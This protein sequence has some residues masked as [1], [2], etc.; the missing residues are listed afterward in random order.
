MIFHPVDNSG[1]T[2]TFLCFLS[3]SPSL[4]L[5]FG[6]SAPRRSYKLISFDKILKKLVTTNSVIVAEYNPVRFR[7]P[8][9]DQ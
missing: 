7:Y 6:R 2:K 4:F 1:N 9:D 5:M 8:T 3:A